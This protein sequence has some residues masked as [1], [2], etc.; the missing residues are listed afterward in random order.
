MNQ[1]GD[2]ETNQVAF[3]RNEGAGCKVRPVMKLLHALEDAFTSL[4]ADVVMVA[5]NF[6]YG[7]DGKT[8]IERDVFHADSH[9][10]IIPGGSRRV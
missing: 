9:E 3:A 8:K 6:G 5:K 2:D 4:G 10:L 7:D 1:I